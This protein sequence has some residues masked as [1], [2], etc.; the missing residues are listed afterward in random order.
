MTNNKNNTIQNEDTEILRFSSSNTK[1]YNTN[2]DFSKNPQVRNLDFGNLHTVQSNNQQSSNKKNTDN[3]IINQEL[4]ESKND[5][6][7]EDMIQQGLNQIENIKMTSDEHKEYQEQSVNTNLLGA[8]KKIFTDDL[9]MNTNQFNTQ[10]NDVPLEDK[11]ETNMQSPNKEKSSNDEA[12]G[13]SFNKNS[14][15][16]EDIRVMDTFNESDNLE[17][18][19]MEASNS[20]NTLIQREFEMFDSNLKLAEFDEKLYSDTNN[21]SKVYQEDIFCDINDELIDNIN[22]RLSQKGLK[23]QQRDSREFIDLEKEKEE[24]NTHFHSP[25]IFSLNED[26]FDNADENK[27]AN[28][29]NC[30]FSHEI[31]NRISPQKNETLNEN[32]IESAKDMNNNDLDSGIVSKSIR[33][34]NEDLGEE[35]RRLEQDLRSSIKHNKDMKCKIVENQKSFR[36]VKRACDE[37]DDQ[38]L[39]LQVKH[40]DLLEEF[41]KNLIN[42][43]D[44]D[45]TKTLSNCIASQSSIINNKYF[46]PGSSISKINGKESI[47]TLSSS[48]DPYFNVSLLNNAHSANPEVERLIG[49]QK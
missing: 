30:S 6:F 31:D 8:L 17:L 20:D 19:R 33:E 28:K 2:F 29:Q 18:T 43:G 37:A 32:Y 26:S 21:N 14:E 46:M 1:N 27:F 22:K 45:N 23:N 34:E 35:Y 44:V 10:S 38:I 11:F 24:K 5:S 16:L 47:E 7:Y 13:F 42:E 9:E 41:R 12:M 36:E 49:N 40:D 39:M 15:V 25:K 4:P 48:L 3:T